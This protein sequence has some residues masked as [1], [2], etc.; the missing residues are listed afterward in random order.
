MPFVQWVV[1]VKE[2]SIRER[3]RGDGGS[4]SNHEGVNIGNQD[5]STLVGDGVLSRDG[6]EGSPLLKV[7]GLVGIGDE[8]VSLGVG[9]GTHDDPAEHGVTAVPDLGLDGGSPSP[10]GELGVLLGPVLY[11]IVKD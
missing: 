10:G 2:K 8:S 6:G 5:N 7:E 3:I 1:R 9:A 11:G 4:K